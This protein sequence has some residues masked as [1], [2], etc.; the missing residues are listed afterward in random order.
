VSVL[1][2][3]H[4]EWLVPLAFL[5]LA[6]LLALALAFLLS[7]RR[8]RLLLGPLGGHV[9]HR[10]LSSDA[11]LL[12]AAA[13]IALALLGPRIGERVVRVPVRGVDT[14]FA[15]D[16]S[17][18]M[19]AADVPP[20]RLAR[21]RRAVVELTDRLE[22]QDRAAL[23]AYAGSGV[24]LAPLTPDRD[25]LGE[26]LSGIDTELLVPGS[27]NLRSGVRTALEAFEAGS[28]RP[29]VVVV[30]SDGEDPERRQ[31][32]GA[33]EALRADARVLTIGFGTEAGSTVPDHGAALVDRSGR[34]V[35]SRR[36]RERL[37]SL[38]GVTDGQA[39]AADAW[40]QIDFDAAARAIRREARAA[41][42][43]LVERRVRAVRVVPFAALAFLILFVEGL[44]RRR[45]RWRKAA[46]RLA[47]ASAALL[48]AAP[49]PAGE[50][51]EDVST[52]LALEA[53]ARERPDDAA[54]L[55]ALGAARLERGKREAAVRAFL[56]AAL[57][58]RDPDAAATAYFDLGVAQLERGDLA[59]AR[60]G[61][62]DALALDPRDEKARFNLEWTLLALEERPPPD[63][64]EPPELPEAPSAPPPA[65]SEPSEPEPPEAE[66]PV[67]QPA[68]LS[69][70]QQRRLLER[71]E[72]DPA[73]ALRSAARQADAM[74]PS[75]RGAPVW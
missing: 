37:A 65:A 21:A 5:Y 10:A 63:P 53:R 7:R 24:L 44:P 6:L 39:F 19:D 48:L 73:H 51:G 8:R 12:L 13:A 72:D 52:L 57:R 54:S 11:L 38:A 61:F 17:R 45:P 2:F 14:V 25:V 66:A 4:P 33:A 30:L 49:T 35:V 9:V 60:D 36:D 15:L 46:L 29:R 34:T 1:R 62:L 64:S 23:V 56:A 32:L 70:E 3:V 67:Q 40:G 68:P 43:T 22:P 55:I 41:P 31:D 69:E 20:S 71:I 26:L 47:S 74:R 58:S 28:E 75:G 50:Q 27:S 18:S 59:A 42:G 16:V